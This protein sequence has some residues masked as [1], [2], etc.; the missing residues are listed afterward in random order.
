[1][2]RSSAS[3]QRRPASILVFSGT[4]WASTA[5]PLV[6]KPGNGWD[7]AQ[8]SLDL[9][10]ILTMDAISRTKRPEKSGRCR[11]ESQR[12]SLYA[13]R[14]FV[15]ELVKTRKYAIAT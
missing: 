3:L 13:E 2:C 6:H 8:H 7:G 15:R 9:L 14:L 4:S 12:H 10:P 5:R 1:M 11:L